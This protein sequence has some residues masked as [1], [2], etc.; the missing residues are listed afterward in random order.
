[1]K[2]RGWDRV[3]RVR[4]KLIVLFVVIAQSWTKFLL[5][6]GFSDSIVLFVVVVQARLNFVQ[7]R[8]CCEFASLQHCPITVADLLAF[9]NLVSIQRVIFC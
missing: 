8:L 1:M 9:L 3:H 5:A 7:A 6:F 4:I 2:I